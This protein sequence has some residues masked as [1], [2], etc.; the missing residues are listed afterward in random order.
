MNKERK[1]FV[2]NVLRAALGLFLFGCGVYLTIQANIGVGAWDVFHQGCSKTFRIRY[3]TASVIISL[4]VLAVDIALKE[5]IGVGMFLDAI[6]VGKTVDLLNRLDIVPLQTNF[7][8]GVGV[9]LLGMIIMGYS[10]YFYMSAG[11]GC[12]PRDSL[13][14]GLSRRI[15]RLPIGVV[16]IIILVGVTLVGYLLG[17]QLGIGTLL[18]ALL[19]G[20]IMEYAFKTMHFDAKKV[21]HQDVLT[22][23]SLFIGK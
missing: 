14:V 11:L 4:M 17:G 2:S 23:V 16:S 20:P 12:G 13:L 9:Q 8:S 21:E 5:K 6:L 1:A 18:C 22:S 10:Q 19:E 15:D 7:W 3:G